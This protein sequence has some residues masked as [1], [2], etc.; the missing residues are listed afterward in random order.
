MQNM[1]HSLSLTLIKKSSLL[2]VGLLNESLHICNDIDLYLRL[3][4]KGKIIHIPEPLILK[5]NHSG[6][7]CKNYWLWSRETI[8]LYNQFFKQSYAQPYQHLQSQV[9]CHAMVRLF[10]LIWP[11]KKDYLFAFWT[12]FRALI[13]DPKYRFIL[14]S[15]RWKK[16]LS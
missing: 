1:I 3:S 9:K 15:K 16:K 12:Q 10:K 7:L 13:F 8:Q 11:V 14:L 4:V 6:N 5:Y 2:E